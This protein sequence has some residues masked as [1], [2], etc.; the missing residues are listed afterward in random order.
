ML[1]SLRLPF[2]FAL[3]DSTGNH[4]SL[5]AAVALAEH[6]L[7]RLTALTAL[8]LNGKASACCHC[9]C[10]RSPTFEQQ[11]K[12]LVC[13]RDTA[14]GSPSP[15][16]HLCNKGMSELFRALPVGRAPLDT[17]SLAGI[18]ARSELQRCLPHARVLDLRRAL[19]C[20]FAR[21]F[22]AG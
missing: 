21:F 11:R 10:F 5:R 19:S 17:L 15:G 16:A 18:V 2:L 9:C 4:V 8:R 13:S 12:L 22:P 14:H 20:S 6:A 7:P 3:L 1:T